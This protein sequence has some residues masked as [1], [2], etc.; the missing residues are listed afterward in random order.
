MKNKKGFTLIEL[1]AVIVI[2]AII[3]LIAT[4][5]VLNMINSAR[6]SAAKSSAYG[7][8]EAIEY[9]NGFA[10]TEQSG[11][12]EINGTDLDVTSSTFNNLKLKGKK[13]TS[14]TVTIVNGKVESATLC[15][16]GYTVKYIK[17]EVTD[18]DKG[19]NGSSSSSSESNETEGVV[20]DSGDVIKYD[21]VENKLCT[22]GDT[23]YKWRVIT[24]GDT[25]TNE[26]ITLQLDHNLLN[27]GYWVYKT[28]YNDDE[29]YG[30]YG[31]NDKGPITALKSLETLTAEWDDSLKLNFT[32]DT[33]QA[34]NNYGILSCTNG[35]CTV[36]GNQITSNLKA[37]MIT[38]EEV[39]ALTKAAG[40]E[41]G[42]NVDNWTLQADNTKRYYFSNLSYD[43]G[44][45]TAVLEGKI[46]STS[47]A[48]LVEN[49]LNYEDS[50]ST[51]N[52]Y[53][54]ST[55]QGYWTMSPFSN[56]SSSA[57]NISY[58]GFFEQKTVNTS[59]IG[60]RPVITISKSA[61]Q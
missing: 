40:A 5:I 61:L 32:Y 44:T 1:L 10:N 19:C 56:N 34:T 50:G 51:S 43:L 3:A 21:P 36:A 18:V 41:S 38:G 42:T 6:K 33:S 16:E 39:K 12:T 7:Y 45:K 17:N 52:T 29:N 55:N 46:G 22:S 35:A 14:G 48:W 27:T 11:Y 9:N 47:L 57:W 23:C 58:Y 2:L 26:T 24:V 13:P 15:V 28:D 31:K 8:I 4:P 59:N 49:T 53:S 37:R 60:V 25:L 54:T 30:S 20:Y